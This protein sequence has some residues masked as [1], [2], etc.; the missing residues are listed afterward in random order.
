LTRAAEPALE[1]RSVSRRFGRR[2]ALRELDLRVAAGEALALLGAN[3]AGKTTFLRLAAGLLLPSAGELRIAGICPVREPERARR[4]IG[5]AMETSRLHPSLSVAGLLRFGAR[6]RGLAGAVAARAVEAM[7]EKTALGAVAKRPI[8][9]CS[10][11][12]QQRV[13]LALALIGDPELLLVDEPSAGLDPAQREDLWEL[14][15]SLRGTHTLVLSTH[16]FDEARQLATRAAVLAEGRLVALAPTAEL[17]A[18]GDPLA[19]FRAGS[20][21]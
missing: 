8:G 10:R 21:Q 3:G 7:L 12:Y 15:A 11:G 19:L 4:R 17:L 5:F 20:A 16:D 2:A 6:A 13:S 1:A 9:N 14:L 18:S